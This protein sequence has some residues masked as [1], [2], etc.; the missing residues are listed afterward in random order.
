MAKRHPGNPF[1]RKKNEPA[2]NRCYGHMNKRPDNAGTMYVPAALSSVQPAPPPVLP[3][4]RLIV[5]N[6]D[7]VHAHDNC[8]PS[9]KRN[10]PEADSDGFDF[11]NFDFDNNEEEEEF[12]W[13]GDEAIVGSDRPNKRASYDESIQHHNLLSSNMAPAVSDS[14]LDSAT[15][16]VTNAT[17]NV[18][19]VTSNSSV[20]ERAM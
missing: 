10:A 6:V 16:A 19:P 9:L 17:T 15:A 20:E 14:N 5:G 13:C 18:A 12:E 4:A 8:C 3:P 2:P 1:Q 7:I 11:G